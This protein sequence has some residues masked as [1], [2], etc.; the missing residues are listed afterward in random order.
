[1]NATAIA[2]LVT[3]VAGLI[4]AITALRHSF[5]TRKRFAQKGS[6]NAPVRNIGPSGTRSGDGT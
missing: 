2:G 4:G 5:N 3:A 1:M 6:F